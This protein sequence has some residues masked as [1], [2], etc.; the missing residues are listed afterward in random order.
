MFYLFLIFSLILSF[1]I[2]SFIKK[3]LFII[4][5]CKYSKSFNI[6][7]R[8]I[9]SDLSYVT[10]EVID[11]VYAPSNLSIL[12]LLSFPAELELGLSHLLNVSSRSLST[13]CTL[14]LIFVIN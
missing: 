2:S 9:L 3:F 6:S 8:Y 10:S 7:L 14:P 11:H 4:F 5:Y 1:S 13:P 12:V